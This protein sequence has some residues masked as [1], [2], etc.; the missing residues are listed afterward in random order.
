MIVLVGMPCEAETA[1]SELRHDWLGNKVQCLEAKTVADM[2]ANPS[3]SRDDFEERLLP[4]GLYDDRLRSLRTL[5]ETLIEGYSP[6]RLVERGPLAQFPEPV[7]TTLKKTLHEQYLKTP[8]HGD[9]RIE[10]LQENLGNATE[11]FSGTLEDF[12]T[13]WFREP[14]ASTSKVRASYQKLLDRASSLREALNHLPRGF[15]LP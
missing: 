7:K 3:P 9:A 6:A 4:D 15:V 11:D 12:R 13:V 2:H 5:V 14:P 8:I 10:E 1:R